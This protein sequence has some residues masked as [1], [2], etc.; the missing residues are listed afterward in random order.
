MW[1]GL[2]IIVLLEHPT[3]PKT[4][5]SADDF[6]FSWRIWRLSSF[7]KWLLR[8]SWLQINNALFQSNVGLLR[9]SHCSV[10]GCIKQV[11]KKRSFCRC[12]QYILIHL[13]RLNYEFNHKTSATSL[14]EGDCTHTIRHFLHSNMH[15]WDPQQSTDNVFSDISL[16]L[17]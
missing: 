4:Q 15:H 6:R 11:L 12:P 5:S 7:L 2:G 13:T 10:N 14:T 1:C 9:L 17:M 8:H 16:F 3:A